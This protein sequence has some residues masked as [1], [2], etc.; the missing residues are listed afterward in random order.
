[1]E[2]LERPSAMTPQQRA[3]LDYAVHLATTG[4]RDP[5][6]EARIRAES[7]RITEEIRAKHGLLDVAVAL[8]REARDGR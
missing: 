6:F 5:E 4:T 8:V 3:D 7:D 2:T 1:M